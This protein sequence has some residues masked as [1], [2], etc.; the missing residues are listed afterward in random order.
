MFGLRS[1]AAVHHRG[2]RDHGAAHDELPAVEAGRNLRWHLRRRI[3]RITV[4]VSHVFFSLGHGA[5]APFRCGHD[6]LARCADGDRAAGSV[7]GCQ[8]LVMFL[9][10]YVSAEIAPRDTND[11]RP[12][13]KSR[14]FRGHHAAG[15]ECSE[16]RPHQGLPRI[17][18]AWARQRRGGDRRKCAESA[19]I[20]RMRPGSEEWL[21]KSRSGEPPAGRR[22]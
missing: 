4:I 16:N 10:R 11:D 8:S 17:S 3:E 2:R 5:P 14:Q 1:R 6:R 12:C 20:N 9:S 21:A 18:K 7:T 13:A 22:P 15:P 19:R